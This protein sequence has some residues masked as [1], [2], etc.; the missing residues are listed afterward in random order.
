MI[1]R[2]RSGDAIDDYWVIKLASSEKRSTGTVGY[3]IESPLSFRTNTSTALTNGR[4]L[5][6]P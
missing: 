5:P 2:F 4:R 1:A 6:A 3:L